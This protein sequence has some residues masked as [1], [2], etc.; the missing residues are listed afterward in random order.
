MMGRPTPRPRRVLQRT[1]KHRGFR[2][3]SRIGRQHC[4]LAR[5]RSV[6]TVRRA[7]LIHFSTGIRIHQFGDGHQSQHRSLGHASPFTNPGHD[8]NEFAQLR[9]PADLAELEQVADAVVSSCPVVPQ[10]RCHQTQNHKPTNGGT[11]ARKAKATASG[12]NASRDGQ[13]RENVGSWR[14]TG[15]RSQIKYFGDQGQKT[16]ES[17]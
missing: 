4:H 14:S 13:S 10:D 6:S 15:P 12:T 3:T 16:R 11:P 5:R 1:K 17:N 8:A 9:N 7:R 2:Q